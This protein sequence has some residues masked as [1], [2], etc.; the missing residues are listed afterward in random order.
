MTIPDYLSD[1]HDTPE[2]KK[3]SHARRYARLYNTPQ[4]QKLWAYLTRAENIVRMETA[5]ELNRPAVEALATRLERDFGADL[6][7]PQDFPRAKQMVGH[8]VRVIMEYERPYK[9][10][11]NNIKVN[12]GTLFSYASRYTLQGEPKS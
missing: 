5:S 6:G 12:V 8:M 10:Q 1:A 7:F 9:W 4:G 2:D 11:R 3:S